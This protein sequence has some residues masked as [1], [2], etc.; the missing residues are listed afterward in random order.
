MRVLR[1]FIEKGPSVES[2]NLAKKNLVSGFINQI[3]SNRKLIGYISMMG[4]YQLPL[5]YLEMFSKKV[6]EVSI[7][8]VKDSFKRRIAKDFAIV[9]VGSK[10]QELNQHEK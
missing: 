10:Q 4:F 3:D 5:N 6:E 8:D 2:F 1:N 7:A 9:M